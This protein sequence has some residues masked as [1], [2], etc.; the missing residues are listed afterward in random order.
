MR[1]S[2]E[3]T[4]IIAFCGKFPILSIICMYNKPIE[5]LNSFKYLSYNLPGITD[6]Q[7]PSILTNFGR[8]MGAININFKQSLIKEHVIITAY[9][10]ILAYG[11]EAWTIQVKDKKIILSNK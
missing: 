4:K 2:I 1:I 8:T 7:L 9:K 5:Q 3:K 6:Q 10:T 11:Y